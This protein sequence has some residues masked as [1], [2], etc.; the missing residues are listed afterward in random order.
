MKFLI[1]TSKGFGLLDNGKLNMIHETDDKRMFGIT[2]DKDHIYVS[3]NKPPSSV[4]M[5]FDKK[6][7]YIREFGNGNLHDVH[8]LY[9]SRSGKLYAVNTKENQI[10]VW[11][12]QAWSVFTWRPRGGKNHFNSVW[13]D[14]EGNLY[15][16]EHNR[17]FTPVRRSRVYMFD[18]N[19]K[20][21]DSFQVGR[22]AHNIIRI[23]D[24]FFICSSCDFTFLEYS[25]R[26]RE[27]VNERDMPDEHIL[28]Y[29]FWHP[30]GLCFDGKTFYIGLSE[31]LPRDRQRF[32][33]KAAI[34]MTDEKLKFKGFIEVP[35][36]GQIYDLRL[37][38]TPDLAHN[39][40]PF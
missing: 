16:I 35:N 30:R 18:K 14:D 13:D 29:D 37:L 32:A 36:V 21:L 10:D 2:W 1:T 7:N 8:Q 4:I 20:R 22:G 6:F 17:H 34:A 26:T 11:N 25:M 19:H 31:W 12:G 38:D 28:S 24:N 5:V 40:I 15:C 27:V 33:L 9:Y 23:R 3:H 39:R